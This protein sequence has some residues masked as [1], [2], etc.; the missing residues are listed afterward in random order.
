MPATERL[1]NGSMDTY[2]SNSYRQ[3]IPFYAV[4]AEHDLEMVNARDLIIT[5]LKVQCIT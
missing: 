3:I 2:V 1:Y 4:W 5:I